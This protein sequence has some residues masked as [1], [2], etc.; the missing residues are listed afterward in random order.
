MTVGISTVN[1]ANKWLD[2][3]FRQVAFTTPAGFYVKWHTGDPGSAGASNAANVAT[4]S[5]ATFSAASGGS[6][7]LSNTPTYTA[8]SSETL[9]HISFWDA[10]TAGN[11]LGSAALTSSRAVVSTD[12]FNLTSLT[13]SM[14]PL[15]A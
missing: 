4:R 13:A 12:V 5:A 3:A 14:T 2:L 7:A 10:S 8:T 6:V 9:S 1:L 15:A 11:F